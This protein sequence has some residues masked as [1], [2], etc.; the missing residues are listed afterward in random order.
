M[1]A[2]LHLKLYP[3]IVS[4]Y[5]PQCSRL[6]MHLGSVRGIAPEIT[7]KRTERGINHYSAEAELVH[8]FY[9]KYACISGLKMYGIA[10]KSD[11]FFQRY[12]AGWNY[13]QTRKQYTSRLLSS[14]ETIIFIGCCPAA[15]MLALQAAVGTKDN[16]HL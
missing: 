10:W 7:V 5:Y 2:L 4:T 13:W 14:T 9:Q 1:Q 3:S 8:H 12:Y 11:N 15:V 16:G 6:K